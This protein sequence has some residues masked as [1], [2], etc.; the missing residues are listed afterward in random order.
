[1]SLVALW[2]RAALALG[3]VLLALAVLQYAIRFLARGLGCIRARGRL[4]EVVESV[5]LGQQSLLHLVRI[6]DRHFVIGT[7]PS[8]V[9]VICEF[10]RERITPVSS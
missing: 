7:S 6:S 4:L 10:P 9:A 8:H 3:V 5:P 2:L 1:V